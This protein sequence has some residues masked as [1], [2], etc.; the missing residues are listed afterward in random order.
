MQLS[1]YQQL[2]SEGEALKREGMQRAVIHAEN[3]NPGW[4]ERA[5]KIVMSYVNGFKPGTEF[6]L[7]DIRI[8][9]KMKD[10]IDT[11]PHER[12]WGSVIVRAA[13]NGVIRK[14]GYTQVVNPKAHHANCALWEVL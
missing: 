1:L 2:I 5:Y 9:A 10:L 11:P 4:S 12:A 7:E 6:K 3:E 13:R 14:K 8:H